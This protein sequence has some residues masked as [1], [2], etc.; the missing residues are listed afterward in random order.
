MGPHD[1]ERGQKL[2]REPIKQKKRMGVYCPGEL[3]DYLTPLVVI[4]GE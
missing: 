3:G 4:L 1:G 2:D